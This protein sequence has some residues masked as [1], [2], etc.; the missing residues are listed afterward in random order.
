M[1]QPNR[2][3]ILFLTLASIAWPA[4]ASS[5]DDTRASYE[6]SVV[7]L[8]VT[9][10]TWDEDRPWVKKKPETRRAFGVVI[11][12]NRILTTSDNLDQATF[13]GVETFGR[14]RPVQFRVE[15]IDRTINLALLS[16]D[17][18]AISNSLEPVAV[19]E[20]TP[21]SGTLRTVRWRGQQLES[22]ASRVIRFEV[23]RTAGSHVY[24]AFLRMRTDMANGGWAE[25]VFDGNAL[26]AITVFQSEDESRAI[27]CEILNLFLERHTAS[28]TAPGF[29]TLG[30]HSQINRDSAVSRFLGQE[31]E[32]RGVLVRQVPWG[33]SAC[34]VIK[35]RDILLELGGDPIDAEGYYRHPLLG[36]LGFNHVLAER[37]QPGD[38][39]S[40]RV[41][42]DGQERELM[43]TARTY[44]AALA[45]IP[46]YRSGPAPYIVA[47]GLII[48]ELDVPY[49]RTWGKE[50]S[51]N[52]PDSLLSRYFYAAEGQTAVRRRTVLIS[53]VLPAAYNLGYQNLRDVVIERVN[54]RAIGR[55]ED[56]ANALE[57]PDNGFHVFDLSLESP[58]G[59]I[60]LDAAT[61][62]TATAEITK[63][64]AVPAARRSRQ[65]SLP[66]GGGECPGDY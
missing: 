52:A 53:S 3:T 41:L 51:K 17:D 59:Q 49:L 44:P 35:P 29:A 61:F 9:V 63:E 12:A 30:V 66:E 50:W 6:R 40:A 16:I 42:R 15:H 24:H 60:V 37:F 32:P 65:E 18:V 11:G 39:V 13:V 2:V 23:E 25:P 38:A 34:G 7:G 62:E 45:L 4:T 1:K 33:S 64:Y 46:F 26:V 55:I 8:S 36:R 28:G 20:R 31:D 43:L 27:P 5:S 57:T 56:V 10:Q 21:T 47:G 19:A 58:R 22:A 48:R 14:A 54:G